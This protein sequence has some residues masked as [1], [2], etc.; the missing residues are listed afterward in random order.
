[1]DKAGAYGIQSFA[2]AFV[3]E[4]QGDYYSIV[5]F[6]IGPVYQGLKKFM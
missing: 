5:G 3:K 1:M 6:P 2:G 4:I